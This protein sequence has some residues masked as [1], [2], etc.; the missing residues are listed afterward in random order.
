MFKKTTLLNDFARLSKLVYGFP[1]TGKTTFA[2]HWVDK[3]GRQPVFIAT[4]DGHGALEVFLQRIKSWEHF[5]KVVE[6]V[7][8]NAE[9][10]KKEHSCFVIDL[11]S[12]LDSW[13]TDYICTENGVPSLTD[14]GFGKGFAMQSNEFQR[15]LR[16]LMN[17]LPVNYIAH[18][19]EKEVNWNGEKIKTQCPSMSSRCLEYINGKVDCI[20]YI[21]TITHRNKTVITMNGKDTCIA[22]SRHKVLCREFDMNY[23]DMSATYNE[24]KTTF[25]KD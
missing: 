17:I 24:I 15:E 16:K 18:T 5:K 6:Y 7:E 2:S 3:E 1:K 25:E 10:I 4:E 12:D 22:G 11:V 20:M 14:L 23:D 8:G 21:D 9:S 19:K 13:C